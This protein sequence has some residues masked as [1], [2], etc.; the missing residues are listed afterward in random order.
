MKI[1]DIK[2]FKEIRINSFLKKVNKSILKT[3]DYFKISTL[4]NVMSLLNILLFYMQNI[5][6]YLHCFR[7]EFFVLISAEAN[8]YV[9]I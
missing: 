5:V 1:S 8:F 9:S 3:H 6:K 2:R 4:I 7:C